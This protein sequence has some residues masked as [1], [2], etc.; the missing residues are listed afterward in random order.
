MRTTVGTKLVYDFSEGS[1]EMRDLLGGKGANVAEMTRLGLPVPRG[2]TIT[3]E[4]CM[5]YLRGGHELPAGLEAEVD[6]HL[7]RLEEEAGRRLGDPADPLLVSVRS[8]AKFSMPGMMDTVLNLGLNDRSVEGLAERTGNAR[9]AYD[10]YRRFISMFGDVVSGVDKAAFE[11]AL[12]EMKDAR[13]AKAD[14]DLSA[15]DLRELVDR[16]KEIFE[17]ERGEPFPQDPRA[18][19]DA[20][21]RA[22]FESWDNRRA[23]DYRRLN[24]IPWDLGTAVNVQQMV[25]GNTGDRSGT[26]VAF[27]RNNTTGEAAEPFGDF[28]INAQGEDVVAGIRTPRPLAEL[29][30]ELPEAYEQLIET[31][32]LLERT[33]RNMQDVEFTIEDG[34]LYMLQTRNG[35]RSAQAMARIAVDMVDEGLVT[36]DEALLDLVDAD[37][38]R[39]LLLPQLDVG[40][41]PEPV[42]RGVN[43]SPGAAVGA[44]VFDA[45]EAERRGK[46]G[47]RV[48]LV[49]DETTPDDLH[50]MIGAQGILT[51]RGGKTSHAAIV[52]VGMG[53]PAVT[54]VSEIELDPENGGMSIAGHH[55]GAGDLITIDGT[56]GGV[57]LGEAPLVPPQADNPHLMRILEWADAARTMRVRTNADTPEDAR[58]AREFGAEGIGLCRTEHMFFAEDRVPIVQE[59]ILAAGEAERLDALERLKPFQE[60][61]FVG[62]LRAMAGLPVTIRLLDPPLHEFLPS[63]LDLTV[64]VALERE[65]GAADPEDERRLA[66]VQELHELNPMLGM[67][68]CRLAIEWP[69]VYRMQVAAIVSAALRVRE[70]TGG[71]PQ[72]EIMIPLVGFE[73]ELRILREEVIAEA[74]RVMEELG[75]RIDF[76]VGTMIEVPRAALTA[77]EIARQADFFSF[78]TNDLTQTT[79][80]FS[81]D[82][83]EGKFLTRYLQ[84]NILSANPFETLDVAG[85]GQLVRMA[86]ERARGAKP[87]IKLGIC[88]EHGG[89]PDSIRFCHEVGLDYVS[90]SPYRVQIA[91][92]AA[93][94]AALAGTAPG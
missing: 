60:E 77:A 26:G 16:Y 81:R 78:G 6:E 14:V 52:A 93:G 90:C 28:L 30:T 61:D 33:Y 48:I 51:A 69:E 55:V 59:M 22:V 41:A 42:A 19:L 35:K 9:F 76:L 3:T 72:V 80:A 25:F 63:L 2:F 11:R 32:G 84:R 79:L 44:V 20:A 50:G 46:A 17:R 86:S 56:G 43:A 31:M 4:A 82:D 15:D 5:A 38:V 65:R 62:I 66:R 87:D 39:Q 1:R 49:R 74:E 7:A 34:R 58:R 75:E 40:Q 94:Q 10:S 70:E 21:I 67:R 85:V 45:D 18:Q 36:S 64:T 57:F 23:Q 24:H 88:G 37:Q 13:G 53:K 47:E 83:A 91:R 8:G 73:E 89:D 92:I 71:E 29:A 54:G 27:T 12:D 68:G